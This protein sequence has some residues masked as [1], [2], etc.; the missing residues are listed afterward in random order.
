MIFLVDIDFQTLWIP[1]NFPLPVRNNL[2]VSNRDLLFPR[3][4]GSQFL[5][6]SSVVP[7]SFKDLLAT[8]P[9]SEIGLE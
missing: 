8:K 1:S 7:T 5:R 9:M 2:P 4:F 6:L 3:E